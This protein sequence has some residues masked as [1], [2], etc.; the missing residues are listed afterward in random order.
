MSFAFSYNFNTGLVNNSDFDRLYLRNSMGFSR[1]SLR[2]EGD[3][4][5]GWPFYSLNSPGT[6]IQNEYLL[7]K[8]YEAKFGTTL[9]ISD[10]Y[11]YLEETTNEDYM[12]SLLSSSQMSYSSNTAQSRIDVYKDMFLE[13]YSILGQAAGYYDSDD[14]TVTGSYKSY[15]FTFGGTNTD[16]LTTKAGLAKAYQELEAEAT[17]LKSNLNIGELG[18]GGYPEI[19]YSKTDDEI[20]LLQKELEAASQQFMKLYDDM[21]AY[22]KIKAGG[23]KYDNDSSDADKAQREREAASAAIITASLAMKYAQ[24]YYSQSVKPTAADFVFGQAGV[25]LKDSTNQSSQEGLLINM[26]SEYTGSADLTN[27][28]DTN[29]S[30]YTM[31]SK[32]FV[33]DGAPLTGQGYVWDLS[34][35]TDDLVDE[36]GDAY[37][38]GSELNTNALD[39]IGDTVPTYISWM[40]R[41]TFGVGGVLP[42]AKN[43]SYCREDATYLAG[44]IIAAAQKLVE[45]KMAIQTKILE[46]SI[47]NRARAEYEARVGA[48]EAI[49]KV[50]GCASGNDPYEITIDGQKYILGQD[51]NDDGTISNITEIL[52]IQDN[53]DNV[54]ASMKKLD[55]N[56]DGYVSQEEM[57][58]QHIVLTAVNAD[59]E[60][61]NSG[62]DMGL[63][64]GISLAS[65]QNMDGTNNVFGKFTMDLQDRQVAGNL[66]FEDK[67]YFDKLFATSVDFTK[68]SE[69]DSEKS[70]DS[71]VV[72]PTLTKTEEVVE[73]APAV[74]EESVPV[75]EA[76][77]YSLFDA[78]NFSFDFISTADSKSV[79]EKILDQLAWKMNIGSLTSV[80]KY[81][82]LDGIDAGLDQD[83]ATAE[84][85]QELDK[86]NLS[87]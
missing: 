54:F 73:E 68:L 23:H 87:A 64:K 53:Q 76:K 10:N 37:D 6:I 66:T 26:L 75:A 77:T 15:D 17:L 44:D 29:N 46:A 48:M 41:D 27:I 4:Y 45:L 56:N 58:A 11:K 13:N 8:E 21:F 50:L 57:Q 39:E 1:D 61:T 2:R 69:Y 42:D 20:D 5:G 74:A 80:Q 34:N 51:R 83:L 22:Y 24:D 16:G 70:S 49:A 55:T 67:T 72:P 59:G 38:R 43:T 36:M 28:F 71:V 18:Y 63:V 79:F 60:L 31:F 52:G 9:A 19:G 32:A 7:S 65:L 62:Y 84:I 35:D 47:N 86:I 85:Q 25:I 12:G 82:I 30:G 14:L 81:Q 3:V 78:S 40:V 33:N